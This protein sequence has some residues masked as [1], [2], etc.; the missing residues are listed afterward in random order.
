MLP[1]LSRESRYPTSR[2]P[3]S[4]PSPLS[5]LSSSSFNRIASSN[6]KSAL[7]KV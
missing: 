2:P 5:S 3:A 7:E 6:M 4:P 1:T